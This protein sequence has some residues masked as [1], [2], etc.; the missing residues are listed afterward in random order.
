M[1]MNDIVLFFPQ[2]QEM[3]TV[4]TSIDFMLK[5]KNIKH[6]MVCVAQSDKLC[7]YQEEPSVY[8]LV[9]DVTVAGITAVL[10]SIRKNNPNMKLVLLADKTISPMAYIKPTILPMALLWRPTERETT[11]NVMKEVFATENGGPD[12]DTAEVEGS[13]SVDIRGVVRMFPYKD[14][15]YFE[16]RD[17][18][19]YLHMGRKEVPFPGTLEHLM[20]ILPDVFMRVHKSI[21]VN[22]TKITEIQFGNN[23][24]ILEGGT[25]VPVSR[26]YKSQVKAVFS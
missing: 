11:I 2:R 9:C 21:I 6:E 18:R 24:L 3:M 22:R 26:S 5:Q 17:K 4:A 8:L 19:L 12:E 7:K 14:I 1:D 10:E 16:S 25:V 15:V 20:E 23:L 13:F